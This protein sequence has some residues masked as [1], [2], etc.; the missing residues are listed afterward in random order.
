MEGFALERATD[1]PE[2]AIAVLHPEEFSRN[3]TAMH[4]TDRDV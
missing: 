2:K 4:L 3:R 1:R